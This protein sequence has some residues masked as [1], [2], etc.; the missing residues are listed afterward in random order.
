MDLSS[1]EF[2]LNFRGFEQD[3]PETVKRFTAFCEANFALSP[4]TFEDTLPSSDAIVL[5]HGESPEALEA[6]AKVLREIGARVEVS[7]EYRIDEGTSLGGPSTQ[8]L[9]RLFGHHHENNTKNVDGP[10]CPYPTLGRTLYLLNR[11]DGVLDRRRLRAKA[12]HSEH[13]QEARPRIARRHQTFF[14]LSAA[15]LVFGTL[16]LIAASLLVKSQ[17]PLLEDQGQRSVFTPREQTENTRNDISINNAPAAK[18]LSANARVSGFTV[19]LKVLVSSRSLSMSALTLVPIVEMGMRDGSTI[20]RIIGDPTFL[21]ESS[22]GEWKGT[23]RLSVFVDLAG[24]KSHLTVPAQISVRM[25]NDNTSGR[26]VLEV[27]HDNME[28]IASTTQELGP[29]ASAHPHTI[30]VELS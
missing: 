6:L 24:Q 23:V 27:T 30:A 5:T 16:A 11:P 22:T 18:T 14:A 15:S 19:D 20:Q 28:S 2:T 26:A 29:H 7:E 9:H 13:I 3:D 17:P 1:K 12:P 21:T 25:S 10:S 4:E 8:E